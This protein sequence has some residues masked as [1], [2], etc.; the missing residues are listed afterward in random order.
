MLTLAS[1]GI[2]EAVRNRG[3]RIK[4]LARRDLSEILELR[5]LIEVPVLGRIA[6]R[7]DP[8]ASSDLQ[9]LV[10]AAKSAARRRDEQAFV[11]SD[12]DYY[13]RLLDLSGNPSA[14]E[15]L[16]ELRDYADLRGL[17]KLCAGRSARELAG[18]LQAILD[19]IRAGSRTQAE[20][21][22]GDHIALIERAWGRA[23]GMSD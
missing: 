2:V 3:Y 16:T 17:S 23:P 22:I 5:R 8:A 4:P 12:R 10:D 20:R 1:L 21:A 6:G 18:Q 14:A 19:A 13:L 9:Q 11:S 15:L 7:L